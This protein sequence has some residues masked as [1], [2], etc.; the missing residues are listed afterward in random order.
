MFGIVSKIKRAVPL[1]RDVG[2]SELNSCHNVT[3]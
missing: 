2:E 1:P 3:A